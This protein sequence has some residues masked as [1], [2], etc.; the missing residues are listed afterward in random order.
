VYFQ[1]SKVLRPT[2]PVLG[3]NYHSSTQEMLPTGFATVN[4]KDSY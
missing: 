3:P 4:S 2:C 1:Y